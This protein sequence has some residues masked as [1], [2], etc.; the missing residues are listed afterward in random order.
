MTMKLYFFE[1]A[2]PV[3]SVLMTLKALDITVELVRLN[4]SEKEQLDASFLELNPTHTVPTLDDNGFVVWDSHAIMQYLVDKYA[5]NDELYPKNFNKRT[6]VNQMLFFDTS[7]LFPS[8]A[9][10][11]R[12]V[13]YDD[14]TSIPT[15]NIVVIEEAFSF[16]ETFLSS[17]EY[18]AGDVLSL[19]DICAVATV[20]TI[21]LFHKLNGDMYPNVK[22]WL[23][24]MK[25]LDFYSENLEGLQ[26]FSDMLLP[27]LKP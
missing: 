25:S 6:K 9:R 27:L 7:I 15:E 14:V 20:T 19:A 4:L 17:Q 12:P 13:F 23:D 1:A 10:A 22:A 16:L 5:I 8:L 11:V 2:P 21:E 3:R 18:L 26:K 24:N